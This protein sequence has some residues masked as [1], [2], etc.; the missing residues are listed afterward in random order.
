M[1]F[2]PHII[3]VDHLSPLGYKTRGHLDSVRAVSVLD[4]RIKTLNSSFL[5]SRGMSRCKAI[6][7]LESKCIWR[8]HFLPHHPSPRKKQSPNLGEGGEGELN[9]NPGGLEVGQPPSL[10]TSQ[11]LCVLGEGENTG[12]RDPSRKVWEPRME[13]LSWW[14]YLEVW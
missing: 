13:H 8:S 12:N 10:L 3:T 4:I 9:G 7:K 1:Y 6:K 14:F 2:I 5:S 11:H